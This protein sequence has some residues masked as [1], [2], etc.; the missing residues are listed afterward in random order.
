MQDHEEPL[1]IP[2]HAPEDA[3]E[4]GDILHTMEEEAPK[5]GKRRDKRKTDNQE[6]RPLRIA[7]FALTIWLSYFLV[8]V[9]TGVLLQ[10]ES[11]LVYAFSACWGLIFTAVTMIL[12]R[13]GGRI[14]YGISYFTFAAWAIAQTGYDQLFNKIMWLADI[15]YADEGMGYADVLLTFPLF[16]WIGSLLLLAMGVILIRLMPKTTGRHRPYLP[17]AVSVTAAVV[18]LLLLPQAIFAL[19]NGVWGTHSEYGQSSSAKASYTVMYDNR[20]VY[21]LCGLYHFTFKDLWKHELYPM[22][23]AYRQEQKRM[24]RDLDDY[25]AGRDDAGE[26]EMTGIYAG[27]NVILV[28]M[29]SMDDWLITEKDTPT[30]CKLMDEGI[31]LT[32]FYTPG[33]GSVRTFNTEFCTNTGI[34]LPTTGEYVFDYVTN[35]FEESMPNSLEAAG[36]DPLCFHYNS[37]SFYSRGV[38]EPAMGYR[39]YVT[40]EDYTDEKN[41][42]YSDVYLWDNPELRDLFFREGQTFNFII[43]RSAH[44]SYTYRE[45]LS[46]YALK[47]YPEYKGAYGHEE[48]DCARVKA[49]LVD[50]MFARLLQELEKEGQLENTVI[51]G[52]TDHYTYGFDD[53]EKLLELSGV[54][55]ELLLEKTPCFIWSYGGP[56]VDVTKTLNTA[57]LLPTVMNLMGLQEDTHYLGQDAF[58]PDY[59]GY[60]IFPNGSWIS[61]GVACKMVEGEPVIILNEK[62]KTITEEDLK[63]MDD[64]AQ[65]FIGHSNML[66]ASDYYAR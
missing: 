60:V 32:N 30:L 20:R 46:H 7:L 29:E 26:N 16:W 15:R 17:A 36:Y 22:T 52:I 21:D 5:A 37:P 3:Q 65:A 54:D 49:K 19:D 23:P 35:D 4:I 38:F 47:Q 34:F 18:G 39:D 56:D 64:I 53:T 43:T 66:L 14:F 61:D 57:D 41:D 59:V 28:L 6:S 31:N 42:L 62:N 45:V 44:L 48:I 10:P 25:F 33:Y 24:V 12:P 40:Y 11:K 9:F 1:N 13:L 63:Q 27:K 55:D 8:E 2:D 51:I 50:D 58:N